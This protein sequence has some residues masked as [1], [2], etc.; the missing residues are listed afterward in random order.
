MQ[1]VMLGAGM[2]SSTTTA[3]SLHPHSLLHTPAT[4]YL[5]T[6]AHFELWLAHSQAQHMQSQHQCTP[7]ALNECMQMLTSAAAKGAQLAE[8][9]C[10]MSSFESG[11][12]GVRNCLEAT[13]AAS[14]CSVARMF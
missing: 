3:T 12:L 13:A 4:S 1:V 7:T 5:H 2:G 8:Q 14:A 11:V 10:S 6:I 9:G